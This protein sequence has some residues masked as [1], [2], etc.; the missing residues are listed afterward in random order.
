[1]VELAYIGNILR[2]FAEEAEGR[3]EGITKRPKRTYR[4]RLKDYLR[5]TLGIGKEM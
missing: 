2:K 5:G 3:L 1:M 4:H